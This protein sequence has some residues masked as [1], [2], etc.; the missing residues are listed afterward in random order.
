M[1]YRYNACSLLLRFYPS[2]NGMIQRYILESRTDSLLVDSHY[3]LDAPE[4]MPAGGCQT[5][6][7]FGRLGA[8]FAEQ[9][10]VKRS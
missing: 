4:Y 3:C 2:M 9:I 7:D 8:N 5:F 6:S 1:T 10:E